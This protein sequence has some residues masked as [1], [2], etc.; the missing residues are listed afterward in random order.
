MANS[1]TWE[2]GRAL[3]S[4]KAQWAPNADSA[5]HT[6]VWLSAGGLGM[7]KASDTAD[8]SPVKGA[9]SIPVLDGT[10]HQHWN[11]WIRLQRSDH[12]NDNQDTQLTHG[13]LN[14][15]TEEP[16]STSLFCKIC[17]ES[18]IHI[19]HAYSLS[20][21]I[22]WH[23]YHIQPSALSVPPPLNLNWG[24]PKARSQG[25]K[26]L[27]GGVLFPDASPKQVCLKQPTCGD[28]HSTE[29]VPDENVPCTRLL[30]LIFF[31]F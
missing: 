19:I 4:L 25:Q 18:I 12:F 30:V 2:A 5:G 21:M 26:V 7:H 13:H 27:W 22:M 28:L 14:S 29:R 6:E 15:L 1:S 20:P 3:L 23:W 8:L 9:A 17:M 31:F 24:L 11:Y 16:N 10:C